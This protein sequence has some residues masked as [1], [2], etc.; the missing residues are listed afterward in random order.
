MDLASLLRAL[1][2]PSAYPF[3]VADVAVRQT[4]ISAVFLAGP[5]V[6]KVKKPVNTGFLDFST[7]GKRQHFCAEEV[8][9]NR[10]LAPDVYLGVVPVVCHGGGLLFEGPGEPVEWAVK[11]R[12]LPE[13]V[14]LHERLL[15]DEVGPALVE[16]LA[17][18]LADFHRRSPAP[19]AWRTESRFDVVSG[20][21]REVFAT[22]RPQVGT[23]V[24]AT[25]FDRVRELVEGELARLRPL[26]DGRAARGLTRDAHGDLHLDHVCYFPD[27]PPPD[28]LVCIDCIEFNERFRFIDP[29]ADAAFAAMDLAYHGRRDLAR[30]F[31]TAYFAASGDDEGRPLLRLFTAYRAAVRGAVD[32]MK[33]AEPEVPPAEHAAALES[34]RGHWLLAL[35]EVEEPARRPALVLVGGLQG[36]GKST[37]SRALAERGGFVHVRSDKVRKELA[38]V[39]GEQR[40][41]EE[42]YSPE[43][44]A[45]TYAECLRRAEERLFEG[46]RVLIDATFAQEGQR[47]LF[48]DAAT[49]LGV[50]ALWLLCRAVPDTV[51]RRLDE[52]R[53]DVSDAG[54]SVYQWAASRWEEPGPATRRATAVIPTDG[55][56]AEALDC[57]AKALREAGLA[58]TSAPSDVGA[59]RATV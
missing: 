51:R 4:H 46:G 3:P 32:G 27:R 58:D 21:I 52:R 55:T 29:V 15:R 20:N 26:I 50:P 43:W 14:T 34:A 44:T 53:G 57:A 2:E 16:A 39:P 40:L 13:G 10:R 28:D 31:A 38:G 23:T 59:R 48:L 1:A 42:F 33:C 25:V 54:W 35:A 41:S 6:Y 7:L 22:A 8:R 45:R 49:R 37:L 36:S 19:E 30:A 11:M 56:P 5:F 17:R 9:L 47:R 12:R 18:K 24:S